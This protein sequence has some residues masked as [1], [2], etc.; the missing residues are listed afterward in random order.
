MNSFAGSRQYNGLL[1][2]RNSTIIS[3][4]TLTIKQNDRLK[5]L[6]AFHALIA[7]VFLF[8][9]SNSEKTGKRD[10]IFSAVY[11][12][13][14]IF[15]LACAI[16]NKKFLRDLSKHL[17]LLLFE[18]MLVLAGSIY[19]WAKGAALVSI[20]HAILGGAI[21][22]LWIYTKRK[23][24]GET[25]VISEANIILPGW[26]QQRIVEWNEITNV[27]KKDDLLTIDFKNNKLLQVQISSV[28]DVNQ[29]AFNRFCQ[30]QLSM[31]NK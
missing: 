7:L 24:G 10:L 16:F 18:L 15:L 26:I 23:E 1:H 14:S 28:D 17:A 27:V 3:V 9:L 12:I 31:R 6:S 29:D 20:S 8:D 19:Y 5:A 21:M 22:L 4:Y 25:I 30:Q 2:V 13:G 11:V